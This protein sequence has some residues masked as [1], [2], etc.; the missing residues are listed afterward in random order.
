MA[1]LRFLFNC[2]IC[3]EE[4]KK[5]TDKVIQVRFFFSHRDGFTLRHGVKLTT[6]KP[7]VRIFRFSFNY[8]LREDFIRNNGLHLFIILQ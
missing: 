2:A 3:Q 1:P 7:C 4:E 8:F 6:L 5:S